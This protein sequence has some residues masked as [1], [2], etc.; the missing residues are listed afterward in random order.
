MDYRNVQWWQVLI[1]SSLRYWIFAG[2]AYVLFY[3]WK[4]QEM[5]RYKI[6][7]RFPK[8]AEVTTEIKY[9]V[10]TMVIFG[11]VIYAVVVPLRPYTQI[12][13]DIDAYSR[14]YYF[15]SIPIVILIHDM[16]FYWAHRIM[17]HRWVFKY[18]HLVHHRSHNPTP[19]AAFSFHPL[20]ALVEVAV[21]PLIVFILPVH[22]S[23]LGI[24]GLYMILMNVVGHLGFE[25]FPERFMKHPVM[26]FFNT[27]THHN[28]HHH[29]G[30]GNCGL[31]FNFWDTLFK[32][33]HERYFDE[34][35]RVSRR[36]RPHEKVVDPTDRAVR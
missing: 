5:F 11:W 15:V 30:R 17:H 26:R 27:S 12:Y 10:S 23:V 14:L 29:H 31:Y 6:Q 7:Q 34:F 28:M 13:N 1:V 9:S 3:V 24:F 21:L 19:L 16:Y 20:E 18:V 35:E 32:T 22:R 36:A 2:L 8:A 4:R 33:N 25:L